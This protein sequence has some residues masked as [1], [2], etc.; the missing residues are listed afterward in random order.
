K[1]YKQGVWYPCLAFLATVIVGVLLFAYYAWKA[2]AFNESA[3][4]DQLPTKIYDKNDNL[5]TT[6]YMGQKREHVK[7]D[8][9]PDKMKDAVLATEDNR[10]Y[11]HGA[12]DY[13]RLSGA[14]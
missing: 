7:F 3:L 12:L 14:F 4:K 2:P 6:L 10:F 8:D 13:K 5:V 9:V 1:N 11:E